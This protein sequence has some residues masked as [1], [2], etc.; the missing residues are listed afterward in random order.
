[1]GCCA[2]P[3]FTAGRVKCHE[4]RSSEEKKNQ[5]L[6]RLVSL[7]YLLIPWASSFL[8]N[9]SALEYETGRGDKPEGNRD[10]GKQWLPSSPVTRGVL[11]NGFNFQL[12]NSLRSDQSQE[13]FH[14]SGFEHA[15][16]LV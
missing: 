13:T 8:S 16:S 15:R 12:N 11:L 2:V 1:V 9:S 7:S 14:Q 6:L 5:Y 4:N 10:K 3:S